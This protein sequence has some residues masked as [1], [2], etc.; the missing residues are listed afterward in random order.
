MQRMAM[1]VEDVVAVIR[2][3]APKHP[4]NQPKAARQ[5]VLA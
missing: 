4:A 1:V 3:K 2:G 5:S